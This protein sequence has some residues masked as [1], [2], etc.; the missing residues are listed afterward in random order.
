MKSNQKHTQIDLVA[1]IETE[2]I[3]ASR[4]ESASHART[5][6]QL[7]AL[8]VIVVIV[9]HFTIIFEDGSFITLGLK[10]CLPWALC[11]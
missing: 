1:L 3:E 9:L 8:T 5:W 4:Q 2:Y 6:L 10:G 7:I 11:H